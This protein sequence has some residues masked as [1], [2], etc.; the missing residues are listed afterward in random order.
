[1]RQREERHGP[2]SPRPAP[3]IGLPAETSA[4]RAF[5]RSFAL[6]TIALTVGYLTWRLAA[7]TVNLGVWWVS[8]PLIA[9]ELHN[10]LGLLLFTTQLWAVDVR[11]PWRPV[12]RTPYRL[13]VLIPT[14]NEPEEVLLP[15]VAAAVRLSPPHE[16]WVLDDGRRPWVREMATELG[17]RYLARPDNRH[18][19]A[20]N[21]NYALECIQADI[22]AVL[23]ADQVPMP[24]F[25]VH[26][27]CYFDDPRVAVVQTPQFFYNQNSFEHA[28]LGEGGQWY[29]EAVFYRVIEAGKNRYNAAFWCGT[30]ALLRVAALRSVGGVATETVAEDM[31]TTLRLHRQ[32]WRT[33]YHNEVLVLGLAPSDA[34]QYWT[35]RQRWAQG[36][37]QVLKVE[38]P[39]FRGLSFG[40]RL[41][42]WATLFAWFDSWRTL[43]YM[44]LPPVVIFS[45]AIPIA[46][47]GYLYGPLFLATFIAQ[48][49]SL[50]LLAR[51][52]YPPLLSLVFE[53]LR[54]PAVLPATLILL[55]PRREVPFRVT[56]KGA[57]G[58]RRPRVPSLLWLLLV[59][60]LGALAWFG[61]TLAGATPTVYHQLGAVAG[62]AVFAATNAA[63]LGAAIWRVVDRRFWGER[64]RGVRFAVSLQGNI[65]GVPC[66]TRDVSLSGARLVA[67]ASPP[68]KAGDALRLVLLL[69]HREVA[70]R[71]VVRGARPLADGTQELR[72][73]FLPGQR[74]LLA[75]L[76][77]GLWAHPQVAAPSPAP[78]GRRRVA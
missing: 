18:A 43:A 54:L 7:G 63:L 22:V 3:S 52:Y 49:V 53:V 44:L 26:T 9:A 41:S 35:Q 55:L 20:G 8:V 61:A 65:D 51:G 74:R 12:H 16:T 62:A 66:E 28:S 36:G 73:E 32:G 23:D 19:K 50:R 78:Q 14:Y 39:L 4:R 46:A 37:M 11:P 27:L 6:F 31:H 47:P 33:V 21:L 2:A 10:A 25:L 15:T 30:N 59:V 58:R 60:S 70:L 76:A 29:E 38:G 77:L 40:Q 56:S 68:A 48:F 57:T 17:A 72:V 13:A 67:M 5:I 71:C 1:M 34:A 64:R 24:N 45:G 75:E 69:P 42:Y